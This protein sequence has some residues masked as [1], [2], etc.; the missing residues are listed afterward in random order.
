MIVENGQCVKVGEFAELF[1]DRVSRRGVGFVRGVFN[2]SNCS[3][4]GAPV[5]DVGRRIRTAGGVS[6]YD[7]RR[8][9][10]ADW[11]KSARVELRLAVGMVAD[12]FA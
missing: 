6:S 10:R 12:P 8:P 3:A 5:S 9:Y 7:R 4:G 11:M 1:L 2:D